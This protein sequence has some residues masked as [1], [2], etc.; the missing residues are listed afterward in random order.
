M[1]TALPYVLLQQLFDEDAPP[2]ILACEKSLY[3]NELTDEAIEVLADQIPLM[4]SPISDTAIFPPTGAYRRAPDGATAF[5][6]RRKGGWWVNMAAAADGRDVYEAERARVR[7]FHDALRPHATGFGGYVNLM[8]N[9]DEE[10]VRDSYGPEKY[11]RIQA[12]KRHW[13]PDNIFHRNAN[14]PPGGG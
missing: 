8:M 1:V 7:C 12:I 2:G 4:S 3:L 6:G 11:R 13:D 5:G 10:L 14:I 9:P